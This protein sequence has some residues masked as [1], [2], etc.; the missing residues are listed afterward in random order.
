MSSACPSP[1]YTAAASRVRVVAEEGSGRLE[2][3]PA[4]L[5][6]SRAPTGSGP[7]ARA[8]TP[9]PAGGGPTSNAARASST[10]ALVAGGGAGE[11]GGL[12]QP[13]TAVRSCGGVAGGVPQLEGP[14]EVAERGAGG[15]RLGRVGGGEQGDERAFAVAGAV[16]VEGELAG[17]VGPAELGVDCC[18]RASATRRWRRVRCGGSRSA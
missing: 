15:D 10:A 4:L 3:G 7:A 6:S 9:R 12:P 18:C 16:E 8:R 13:V 17:P 11:L 5:E 14:L 1:A 2:L